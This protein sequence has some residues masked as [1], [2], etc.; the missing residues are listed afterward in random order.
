MKKTT[1]REIHNNILNW[2]KKNGRVTLPWRNSS[3][4]YEIYLSE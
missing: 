2:Y 1:Y 4:A 3:S